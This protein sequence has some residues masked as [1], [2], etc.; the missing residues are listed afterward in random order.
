LVQ[1]KSELQEIINLN[2]VPPSTLAIQPKLWNEFIRGFIWK[3]PQ[4]GAS[5]T[6]STVVV[7]REY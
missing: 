6:S 1:L 7:L 4:K 3:E 2:V 5:S